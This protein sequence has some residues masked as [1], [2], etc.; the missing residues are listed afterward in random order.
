M[1]VMVT[2]KLRWLGY[3]ERLDTSSIPKSLLVSRPVKGKRSVGSQQNRW[4]VGV[5]SG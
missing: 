1:D 4:N 3:M 2:R 5:V